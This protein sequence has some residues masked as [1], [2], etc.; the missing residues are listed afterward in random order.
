MQNIQFYNIYESKSMPYIEYK[1]SPII[2][3]PI[4]H[5]SINVN[6]KN[7]V[8]NKT[9][10]FHPPSIHYY[11]SQNPFLSGV[12]NTCD[13]AV[14]SQKLKKNVSWKE[15]N[16]LGETF[17]K[18]DYDRRVDSEQINKNMKAKMHYHMLKTH[19]QPLVRQ[20]SIFQQLD[21]MDFQ[22]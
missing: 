14:S 1:T 10:I 8:Q 12:N 13:T 3:E 17:S 18:D 21:E 15:I 6:V 2:I 11:I 22:K 4:K 7:P 16:L 20:S 19:P 9:T 5:I